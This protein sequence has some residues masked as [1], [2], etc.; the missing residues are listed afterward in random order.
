MTAA[1]P[2][3]RAH[4]EPEENEYLP[5]AAALDAADDAYGRLLQSL[6]N[7]IESGLKQAIEHDLVAE[8][9]QVLAK[10]PE[11]LPEASKKQEQDSVAS[12]DQ[13]R[14]ERSKGML[15]AEEVNRLL[16]FL[17]CVQALD[18]HARRAKADSPA[19]KRDAAC[20]AFL[21]VEIEKLKG[22]VK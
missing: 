21:R 7:Q 16:G 17:N 18:E 15:A 19:Q 8:L 6:L 13:P 22:G 9:R 4:H 5:D 10:F 2:A 14:A 1:A 20:A 3:P 12:A 11:V